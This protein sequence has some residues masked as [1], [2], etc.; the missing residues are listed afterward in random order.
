MIACT[1][2]STSRC[3]SVRSP[4][5]STRSIPRGSRGSGTG[6]DTLFSARVAVPDIG[7]SMPPVHDRSLLVVYRA[8]TEA[9][10]PGISHQGLTRPHP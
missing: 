8:I 6:C 5:R 7:K 1:A 4:Q 10:A 3:G 9:Q 2:E